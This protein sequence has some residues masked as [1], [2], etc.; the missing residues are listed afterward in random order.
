MALPWDWLIAGGLAL[1]LLGLALGV[2]T[3]LV[4]HLRLREALLREHA[5]ER[6]W[7]LRPVSLHERITA[8]DMGRVLPWFRAGAASFVVVILGSVLMVIGVMKA[9]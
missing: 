9:G 3:G 4:Y 5:L 7:W 2:P 8:P 1:G 6:R